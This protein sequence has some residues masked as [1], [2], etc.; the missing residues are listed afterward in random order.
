M[1]WDKSFLYFE[2]QGIS[3]YN[4]NET[5]EKLKEQEMFVKHIAPVAKKKRKEKVI[6]SRE[7][8]VKF[9]RSLILVLFKIRVSFLKKACLI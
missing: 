6:F 1:S 7:V 4:R 9:I 5:V 3:I 8:M 2:Q